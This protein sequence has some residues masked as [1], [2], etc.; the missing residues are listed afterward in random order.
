MPDDGFYDGWDLSRPGLTGRSHFY[1]LTPIG[2][3]TA[4]VESLTGYISRLAA[5]HSVETGVLVNH[6]LLPR[7]PLTK[8][9]RSGQTPLWQ[10][11]YSFFLDAH[12]LNGTGDRAR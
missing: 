10:P 6:E 11:E 8:G 3:R 4:G 5:A 7:V 1:S 9:P 2:V 12:S